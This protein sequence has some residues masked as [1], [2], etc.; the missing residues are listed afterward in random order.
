M[1]RT[2]R[3][4]IKEQFQKS[5]H[6]IN[7]QD[8]ISE[9]LFKIFEQVRQLNE[10]MANHV[11]IQQ[12]KKS[13]I[14]SLERLLVTEDD[15]KVFLGEIKKQDAVLYEISSKFAKLTNEAKLILDKIKE[16]SQERKSQY[17]VSEGEEPQNHHKQLP[18]DVRNKLDQT[19][20]EVDNLHLSFDKFT[21]QTQSVI[22]SLHEAQEKVLK[23]RQ[24]ASVSG[25]ENLF[26]KIQNHQKEKSAAVFGS[27]GNGIYQDA[28]LRDLELKI[29]ERSKQLEKTIQQ[30]ASTEKWVS[31]ALTLISMLLMGA[32]WMKSQRAGKKRVASF[33]PSG[34]AQQD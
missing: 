7:P 14:K 10:E 11:D 21:L 33:P 8:D 19:I 12:E 27:R 22:L 9:V 30:R 31:G 13:S 16:K 20:N 2:H 15:Y 18:S 23:L 25:N 28:V 5:L 26:N 17:Q 29:A 34:F 3:E 32:L 6:I 4:Y 24:E 1:K